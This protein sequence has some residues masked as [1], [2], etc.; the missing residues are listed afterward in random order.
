MFLRRILDVDNG[1]G[2]YYFRSSAFTR[3][4]EDYAQ[5]NN[6][7]TIDNYVRG[8]LIELGMDFCYSACLDRLVTHRTRMYRLAQSRIRYLIKVSKADS[9]YIQLMKNAIGLIAGDPKVSVA[10]LKSIVCKDDNEKHVIMQLEEMLKSFS[11]LFKVVSC[12][13][14]G[15]QL[16]LPANKQGKVVCPACS[17][18]FFAQS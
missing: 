8:Q 1:P 11:F 2:G 17:K 6:I 12:H 15:R 16:R 10:D 4:I 7:D 5:H 14:C 13:S 3:L 9:F 18:A